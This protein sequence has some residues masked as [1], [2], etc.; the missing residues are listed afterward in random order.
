MIDT[1][2]LNS[3][4]EEFI[5]RFGASYNY[6]MIFGQVSSDEQMPY[7]DNGTVIKVLISK[8]TKRVIHFS[9]FI[10][11][12]GIT[13]RTTTMSEKHFFIYLTMQ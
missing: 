7:I 1:V 4:N 3:R 6:V 11:M 12:Q 10:F 5:Y 8:F 9:L 13:E 2:L